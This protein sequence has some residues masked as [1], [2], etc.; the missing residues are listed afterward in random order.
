[1]S[2]CIYSGF[3]YIPTVSDGFRRLPIFN[4]LYVNFL[5]TFQK[6]F[7]EYLEIWSGNTAWIYCLFVEIYMVRT[8]ELY[9]IYLEI[10]LWYLASQK[11][12]RENMAA[13]CQ[14][15]VIFTSH[16]YGHDHWPAINAVKVS[17]NK[18]FSPPVF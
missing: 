6:S 8:T 18:I 5:W 1:M 11:C 16:F 12:V 2:L 10:V 14:K 3:P 9:L 4:F 17:Q 7:H 13:F 15:Y